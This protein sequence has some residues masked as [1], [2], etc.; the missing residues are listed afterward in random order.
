MKQRKRIRFVLPEIQRRLVAVTVACVGTSV[1]LGVCLTAMAYTQLAGAL[2]SDGDIVM[3]RMPGAL[4][5]TA[6]VGMAV[7]LPA[8]LALALA[9]T[10]PLMGVLYHFG[11]FLRRTADGSQVEECKLRA[12]DPLQG[13]AA[14][15]NEATAEKR[16]VNGMAPP[17]DERAAA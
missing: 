17:N 3:E 7:A 8:F 15:L 16:R 14:L 5:R 11:A 12:R 6:L 2:P 9:L 4:W 1:V 10:M 13:L